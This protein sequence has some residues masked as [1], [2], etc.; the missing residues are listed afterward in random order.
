MKPRLLFISFFLIAL[1][2]AL[3]FIASEFYFYWTISWFDTMM[4]FLGGISLG[5]FSLWVAY[6]AGL[7]KKMPLSRSAIIV[8]A[9]FSVLIIGVG[10]E[11]FEKMNGL[12]QST[13]GYRLD[14]IHDLLADM[15]GA[16]VAGFIGG[17]SKL[18]E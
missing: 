11:I 5:L 9:F 7:F 10:W 17:C 16:L 1:L 6:S 8:T 18:Y 15:A 13:E 4:H 2:G 3:H 12:T 14:T